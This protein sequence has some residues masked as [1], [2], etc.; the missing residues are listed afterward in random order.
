[1]LLGKAPP[2]Q[3]EEIELP[4]CVTYLW[5]WFCELSGGRD[6]GEAGPKPLSYREIQS[7]SELTKTDPTAWEV[8]AIKAIDRVFIAEA[9]K[10]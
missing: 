2:K 9:N 7:W 4:Y 8:Q 3:L 1:M 5:G 6:Y 10:K